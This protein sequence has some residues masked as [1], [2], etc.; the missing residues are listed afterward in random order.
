MTNIHNLCGNYGVTP[1]VITL[2]GHPLRTLVVE[3]IASLNP[4]LVV[5]DRYVTMHMKLLII[6]FYSMSMRRQF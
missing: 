2:M 5:I 6:F 4:T 3:R 1:H